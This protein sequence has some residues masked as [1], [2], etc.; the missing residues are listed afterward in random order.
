MRA[1]WIASML[2]TRF[3]WLGGPWNLRSLVA[4]RDFAG[5]EVRA[6]CPV[7][8]TPPAELIGRLPGSF[9]A[10]REWQTLHRRTRG[11][12]VLDGV[13]VSYRHWC[14][15]PKRLFWRYEGRL[16]HA[17][18]RRELG[19]IVREFRPDVIHAPWLHPEGSAAA[20]LGAEHGIPVVAQGIGNDANHY[21]HLYGGRELVIRDLQRA[22]VLLFNC[23]STRRMAA[24]AGLTHP[25]VEVIYHGVDVDKFTL[26]ET[27]P[28]N[29]V[30]R[31]ITVAQLI[32]RKNHQL[33]L[34]AYAQLPPDVR[35][36]ATL[37]FVGG[38]PIQPQLERLAAELGIGDRVRFAG[39]IS[40]EE[41][42]RDLQQSDL[43]CLP[44]HSEGMPVATIEAMACGLPVVASNVD[45][46]PESVVEGV[47]GMLVPP[48]DAGALAAALQ[49]ALARAWDRQAVRNIVL[50]KFTWQ[51]YAKNVA[52]LYAS[53]RRGK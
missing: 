6:V 27:P 10:L 18:L 48:A 47:S 20:L 15:L 34:R 8:M 50:E 33:L 9:G 38:G 51:L 44:T 52:E 17:Q 5:V 43:F 19:R 26:P 7:G 28:R 35:R 4:L 24:Q 40:H 3:N 45:G 49:T 31:I 2:P 39:R 30:K 41:M 32:P 1:L 42:I 12:V 13:P 22:S 46:I 23:Q 21:L 16:L 25:R 36:G 14:W 11:D 37:E 53:V 29:A